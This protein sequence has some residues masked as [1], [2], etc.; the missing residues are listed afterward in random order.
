MFHVNLS[1]MQLLRLDPS[2]ASDYRALMLN[3]YAQH[4][5]AFTSSV[6]ERATLPL[7][8]WQA[9]LAP[10][11]DPTE[12]VFG[13]V[14]GQELAGVA[15]LAFDRRDKV[16]HKAS[17]FGMFVRTQHRQMG[18]GSRLVEHALAYARTRSGVL[19]VQLTVT[20]GNHAA[21]SLYERHGFVSY[22]RE[23]MA[24]ALESGYVNKLHMWCKLETSPAE[25]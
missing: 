4:P 24:V 2:H 13:C 7:S 17:L 19:L 23:P 6:N 11:D 3:A 14:L 25:A 22:G 8:W 5:E 12:L 20:Q 15:G 10:G 1:H 21:Q 18:I 9:R 16:R